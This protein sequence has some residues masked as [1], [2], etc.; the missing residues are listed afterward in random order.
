V[1]M[2]KKSGTT[3]RGVYVVQ[4]LFNGHTWNLSDDPTLLVDDVCA[5]RFQTRSEADS[6][7]D[8][9]FR[10]RRLFAFD[11]ATGERVPVKRLE[12][13]HFRVIPVPVGPS[14]LHRAGRAEYYQRAYE[15]RKRAK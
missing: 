3:T 11:S 8:A 9:L 14:V 15:T 13:T 2:S 12:V 10:K 7:R 4:V 6:A 5:S 1:T